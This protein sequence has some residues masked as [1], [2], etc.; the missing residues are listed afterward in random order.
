M[1][2]DDQCP[3]RIKKHTHTYIYREINDDAR[4]LKL[5]PK[6]MTLSAFT[7]N[8]ADSALSGEADSWEMEVRPLPLPLTK[9]NGLFFGITTLPLR[10]P[11]HTC[12]RHQSAAYPSYCNKD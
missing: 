5:M 10:A 6:T 12:S 8:A 4:T 3:F 7:V 11:P 2:S 9:M 1:V